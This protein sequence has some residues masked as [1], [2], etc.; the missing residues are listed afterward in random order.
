MTYL[1]IYL[2]EALDV[3]LRH[4]QRYPQRPAHQNL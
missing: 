1:A 4:R 2:V 3:H